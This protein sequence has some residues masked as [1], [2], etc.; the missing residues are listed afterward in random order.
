MPSDAPP[1]P[2]L[3]APD[4]MPTIKKFSST[5]D[6]RKDKK[7]SATTPIISNP[8]ISSPINSAPVSSSPGTSHPCANAPR[9]NTPRADTPRTNTPG[10]IAPSNNTPTTSTSAM[11]TPS[12]STP[13]NNTPGTRTPSIS[14][15]S[16]TTTGMSTP[17]IGNPSTNKSAASIPVTM[18][19]STA[20]PP[21]A[22]LPAA[23]ATA[24]LPQSSQFSPIPR[25]EFDGQVRDRNGKI[26]LRKTSRI[27]PGLPS[28]NIH[29]TTYGT[30][31][32]YKYALSSPRTPT[33]L[34]IDIRESSD[35]GKSRLTGTTAYTVSRDPSMSNFVSASPGSY[36]A[37]EQTPGRTSDKRAT[38]ILR[39]APKQRA[40]TDT[41]AA[42]QESMTPAPLRIASAGDRPTGQD[43]IPPLSFKKGA[44]FEDEA[45]QPRPR[46]SAPR[47]E[48][49]EAEKRIST[50]ST[51]T[52][53]TK[54][55]KT[56]E[57]INKLYGSDLGQP[58]GPQEQE[59]APS[60]TAAT[61][62]DWESV[63][64]EGSIALEIYQQTRDYF[65]MPEAK[66]SR[67]R[68]PNHQYDWWSK[69]L[70]CQTHGNGKEH[71]IKLCGICERACCLYGESYLH[72]EGRHPKPCTPKMAIKSRKIRDELREK[73]PE[74]VEPFTSFLHCSDCRRILCPDHCRQ[75]A[76]DACCTECL[77][78][79]EPKDKN[80]K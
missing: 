6:I 27:F 60:S 32:E 1:M 15:H 76:H 25:N 72:A 55:D 70:M 39:F 49:E 66:F 75:M 20:S 37:A 3:P 24:P 8:V 19:P 38:E 74:G 33:G 47:A 11:R 35:S 43:F 12:I 48:A 54:I 17:V 4:K 42:Q 57:Q 18:T 77:W 10:N 41:R 22:S 23:P 13:S 78:G 34:G 80:K 69:F 30:H 29:S 63:H 36:H 51:L 59:V 7:R 61:D 45:A 67:T 71:T 65:G 58:S 73:R 62:N 26:V 68:H 52:L 79:E 2:P 64:S 14:N 50:F 31:P 56:V 9:A 5:L 40:V 28:P 21:A 53:G 46:K 16:T 44:T